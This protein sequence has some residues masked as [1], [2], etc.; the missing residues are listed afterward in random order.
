M[1]YQLSSDVWLH[2]QVNRCKGVLLMHMDPNETYTLQEMLALCADLG[3]VY[4]MEVYQ[5][6]GQCL[7]AEGF[8]VQTGG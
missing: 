5:Q 8:L 6:I 3:L 7:L 2:A 4:S 1:G